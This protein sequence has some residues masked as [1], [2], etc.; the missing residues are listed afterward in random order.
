MKKTTAMIL[1]ALFAVL[2][3]MGTFLRIPMPVGS[4]TLQV[5]FTAMAGVLLGRRWGAASQAVYLLLGLMGLPV[6][7]TGGGIQAFL[8]P[9]GGFLLAMVPMAWTVG[10]IT[11]KKGCG[12]GAVCLSCCAGLMILYVVGLPWLHIY[13][14]VF[15]EE[16]WSLSQT[17]LTGMVIFLPWDLVKILLTAVLCPRLRRNLSRS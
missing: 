10:L 7:T 9:T 3:A 1:T 13:C 15:L 6:F 16:T 11:E 14:T 2:T 5:L 8:Q 17:L 12:F 4:F